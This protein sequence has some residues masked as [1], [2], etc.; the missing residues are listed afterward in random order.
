MPPV[1]RPVP[2]F[3]A[4]P[5][6]EGLPYG[7]W[8]QRLERELRCAWAALADAEDDFGEPGE[9]LWYPDRTWHGRR[10]VPATATSAG[11][12]ELYGYVRYLTGLDEQD[13][14]R[15]LSAHVDFTDE[16]AARH[17]EW[18]LDLCD[19]VVGS[20][21]GGEGNAAAMTL[22][23]GRPL[24][25]DGRLVT[26][27]L[28]R[29]PAGAEAVGGARAG[30]GARVAVRVAVLSSDGSPRGRPTPGGASRRPGRPKAAAPQPTA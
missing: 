8:A 3:A 29:R 20:W 28:P 26:R 12:R 27:R 9:I 4:E 5:P 23:W 25:G 21:R 24:V 19:E 13:E 6:Q 11:G 15:E 2:S 10:Y 30:A 7:R 18:K 22:V 14:P 1:A 17:P 16:T